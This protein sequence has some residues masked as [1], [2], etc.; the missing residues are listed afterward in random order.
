MF[1]TVILGVRRALQDAD[2]P[3]HPLR[4][5]AS[6][7]GRHGRH[8]RL[9]RALRGRRHVRDAGRA[10]RR[11]PLDRLRR[12]L[13]REHDE[14]PRLH[15][16]RRGHLRQVATG[17]GLRRDAPLRVRL[18]ARDPAPAR[19]GHLGEPHLDAPVRPH[20]RS[21]SSASSDARSRRPPSAARTSSSEERQGGRSGL[22]RAP[23]ARRARRSLSRPRLSSTASSSS[24]PPPPCWSAQS[25]PSSRSASAARRGSL[26]SARSDGSAARRLRASG[27]SWEGWR[28]CS[29]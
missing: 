25:W 22:R 8:L 29:T 28:S 18:R 12:E 15:R 23:R 2:R 4:R 19:G 20:A 17:L 9:R 11:L 6:E 21:R 16:A 24:R 1:A 27:A 26:T 5:R 13:R 3:A 14:R 7:G 10:R